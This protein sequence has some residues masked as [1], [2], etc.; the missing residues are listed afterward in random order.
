[1]RIGVVKDPALLNMRREGPFP[2]AGV[3]GGG[4]CM[5]GE[6]V[7][8]HEGVSIGGSFAGNLSGGEDRPRSAALP[9]LFY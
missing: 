7:E 3:G 4:C 2:W 8:L 9:L 1:M 5:G 6:L